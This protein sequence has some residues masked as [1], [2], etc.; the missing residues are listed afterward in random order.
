MRS[1]LW[2][3]GGTGMTFLLTAL[4]AALVFIFRR[5]IGTRARS[6]CFSFTAGVMAAACVF[7]LLIPA[8]EAAGDGAPLVITAGFLGGA[9]VI[10]GIDA[11]LRRSARL[12]QADDGQR[13]TAL[14]FSAVT[15]HNIPEGLAVGLALAMAA[16][17]QGASAAAAALALGVGLQNIPEGAAISLPLSAQ[18]MSRGR[19]FLWGALSGAV[20]PAAGLAAAMMTA[21]LAPAVPLLMA[22]AAGAMMLVVFQEMIPEAALCPAGAAAAVAGYALMMAMDVG[23]G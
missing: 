6:V 3:A 12:R 9:G 21:L 17:G 11:L 23:L 19:S 10:A 13:R 20:E 2:A 15:L 14:L 8:L 22:M 16:R 5:G 4:G 18:G 7:S 1:F